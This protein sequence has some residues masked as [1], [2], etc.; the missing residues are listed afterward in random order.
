MLVSTCF[1]SVSLICYQPFVNQRFADLVDVCVISA[2]VNQRLADL[3][4]VYVISV[5]LIHVR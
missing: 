2:L 4:D 1:I 5:A 3:V